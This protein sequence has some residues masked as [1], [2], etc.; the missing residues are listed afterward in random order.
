V[1]GIEQGL[2]PLRRILGC[3]DRRRGQLHK[4]RQFLQH[5]R[6]EGGG[7]GKDLNSNRQLAFI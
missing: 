5:P 1:N 6:L 4:W 2:L 3:Q 7:K